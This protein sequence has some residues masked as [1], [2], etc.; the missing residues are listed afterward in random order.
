[1][2]FITLGGYERRVSKIKKY[3]IDW[4]GKSKSKIQFKS[5]KFLEKY[6]KNHVVFEEFPVAGTL[7]SLDFYNASKKIAVEVQGGQHRRYVPFFHN[8]YKNNYLD[9][10][11]RDRDKRKFC[12]IN[13]ITLVEVYDTDKISK[14]LFKKFNVSL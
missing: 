4:D 14:S 13:D 12:E 8:N 3:I 11:R 9:Q 1:M 2:K 5:K 10:L 7:L 6:W